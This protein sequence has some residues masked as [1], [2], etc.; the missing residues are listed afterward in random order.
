MLA[1]TFLTDP[2]RFTLAMG[3]YSMAGSQYNQTPWSDFAAMAILITVPVVMLFF[4]PAT[5]DRFGLAGRD[6]E[7]IAWQHRSWPGVAIL[8]VRIWSG[9]HRAMSRRMTLRITHYQ[10]PLFLAGAA[11]MKDAADTLWRLDG[12]CKTHQLEIC[13]S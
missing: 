3:L 10:S 9:R 12:S 4:S 1:W 2:N 8:Y 11:S 5:L 13:R 6:R 7:G